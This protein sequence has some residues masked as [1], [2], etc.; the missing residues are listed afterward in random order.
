[1]LE[2]TNLTEERDFFEEG[3]SERDSVEVR[4]S[5]VPTADDIFDEGAFMPDG[6][7]KDDELP[8]ELF[9]TE[10]VVGTEELFDE[11]EAA[12]EALFDEDEFYKGKYNGE[13]FKIPKQAAESGAA[14]LGV[15]VAEYI[16]TIQK[17]MNYD[18]IRESSVKL[19]DYKT[20]AEMAADEGLPVEKYIR[21]IAEE[22]GEREL[23]KSLGLLRAKFPQADEELLRE[24][25]AARSQERL[26]LSKNLAESR[27]AAA[28]TTTDSAWERF[29]TEYPRIS[30]DR[31]PN[32]VLESVA[33]GNDPL[34]LMKEHELRQLRGRLTQMEWNERVRNK[35]LPDMSGSGGDTGDDFLKG[36]FGT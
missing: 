16:A 34:T 35:S 9:D 10:E 4:Q 8:P 21:R 12:E 5:E 13:A 15:S 27:E 32:E 29:F 25:A 20:L 23:N 14:A 6:A 18:H 22:R 1:M 17:G 2:K 28:E 7:H 36:F 3:F 11:G 19:A 26:R 30:P 33:E 31:I 24:L